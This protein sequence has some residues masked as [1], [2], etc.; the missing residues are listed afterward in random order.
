MDIKVQKKA[1]TW[2]QWCLADVAKARISSISH[3][4]RKK[5]SK[6]ERRKGR[7]KGNPKEEKPGSSGALLMF[8]KPD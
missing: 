1:G 6:K 8:P 5:E 7:G 2:K 4:E 3:K